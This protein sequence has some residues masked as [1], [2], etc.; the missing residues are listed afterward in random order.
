MPK[1]DLR[2]IAHSAAADLRPP[3]QGLAGMVGP[4]VLANARRV[5]LD[6]IDPN[7]HQA[8]Q[9]FDPAALDELAA[10]IA[11]HGV[12]E[13]ILIRPGREARYQI[14]VGERRYRAARLAGLREIP[15]L[16]REDLSEV[17]AALIT[18]TENLQREDLDLE[19]EA[20]Q[21][22]QLLALTG[23][24]QRRLAERLGIGYN[25]LSRRVRLLERPDLL[26]AVREGRLPLNDALAQ[27]SE[28]REAPDAPPLVERADLDAATAA[29][30]GAADAADGVSAGHR[31]THAT[32]LRW[33][34]LDDA[35]R[36]LKRI[37]PE[38]VPEPERGEWARRLRA[39]ADYAVQLAQALESDAHE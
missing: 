28:D 30:P 7:P 27:L 29:E 22:A 13:P 11:A 15:A 12:L 35:Y 36:P 2:T 33:R 23:L 17:D 32:A 14:V 19:D 20:R 10:S 39:L 38:R 18:A 8:R 34:Y 1:R 6:R 25:Y 24:S 26:A 3:Q 16:I 5:P 37:A 21:F 4:G 9:A 31:G